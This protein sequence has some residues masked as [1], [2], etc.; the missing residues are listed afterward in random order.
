MKLKILLIILAIGALASCKQSAPVKKETISNSVTNDGSALSLNKKI[1]A[2]AMKYNDPY[3]ALYSAHA[4]IEL[5][6]QH[7][8]KYL[9]TLVKLYSALSMSGAALQLADQILVKEPDNKKMLEIKVSGYLAQGDVNGALNLTR[10]LYSMGNNPKYLYQVAY[11]QIESMN[12]KDAE[13]TLDQVEA[14]PRYAKDSVDFQTATPGVMQNV[15]LEAATIYL[16]GYVNIQKKRYPEAMTKFK[17][18]LTRYPNFYMAA[19]NL[20]LLQQG[21]AQGGQRR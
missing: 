1:F 8:R 7:S 9:D 3:T 15:P 14:H 2:R 20:Q 17:E 21:M 11:I 5:D 18:A 19:K 6:S 10:K 13:A 4:I 12:I 16:R